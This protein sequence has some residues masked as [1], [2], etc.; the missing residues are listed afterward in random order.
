[1]NARNPVPHTVAIV[2]DHALILDGV[3]NWIS[4]N[5]PDLDVTIRATS[6]VE[7]VRHPAF[8]P[9]VV[10]MDLQLKEPIS[11]E[12]RIRI[13]RSVGAAVVVM[14]AL[15]APETIRRVL[16]AGAASFVSKAQ[17]ATDLLDA[18]R[19][20]L[21]GQTGSVVA[22]DEPDRGGPRV[23]TS[24]IRFSEEEEE[25][26]RLY[27]SGHTPVEVAMILGTN[28]QAVKNALERVREQYASEGRVA[29]RKQDLALRAAEDGYLA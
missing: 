10:L 24:S 15:D 19:A 13:C 25:T 1:M 21:G 29:E 7:A 11:V 2:D 4:G 23:M 9:E 28:I 6:W 26:L 20:V 5:A 14:S 17:P 16:D 3:S 22:W 12:A 27:V 8:P 18:V